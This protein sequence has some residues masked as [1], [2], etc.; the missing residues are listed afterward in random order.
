MPRGK[1]CHYGRN[2]DKC[3]SKSKRIV[4]WLF[5]F[6]FSTSWSNLNCLFWWHFSDDKSELLTKNAC[7]E[8]QIA[9]M[10][11]TV[12]SLLTV[13]SS[14]RWLIPKQTWTN[15]LVTIYFTLYY[16][17]EC[18]LFLK[19]EWFIFFLFAEVNSKLVEKISFLQDEDKKMQFDLQERRNKERL[20]DKMGMMNHLKED[21]KT[22]RTDVTVEILG[23]WSDLMNR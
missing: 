5:F 16:L 8:D 6:V 9:E 21:L 19:F 2:N 17:K 14:R 20:N 11:E 15:C 22:K 4:R 7:L 13:L 18:L 1:S 10:E 3:R 12:S 23:S